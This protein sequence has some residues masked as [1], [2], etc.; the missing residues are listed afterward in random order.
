MVDVKKCVDE[1]EV[2][3]V[4]QNV[5]DVGM[6]LSHR[7]QDRMLEDMH[8]SMSVYYQTLKRAVNTETM[9]KKWYMEKSNV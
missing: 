9:V 2:G 1:S 7:D 3:E 4:P 6:A 8:Q 5:E